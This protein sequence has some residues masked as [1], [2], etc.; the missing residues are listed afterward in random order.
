ML[1]FLGVERGDTHHDKL[2]ARDRYRVAQRAVSLAVGR[3]GDVSP[4]QGEPHQQFAFRWGKASYEISDSDGIYFPDN[5][6]FATAAVIAAAGSDCRASVRV[7]AILRLLKG[8]FL[9]S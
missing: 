7:A 2:N 4:K 3:A 9:L 1:S 6:V 8:D 5:K